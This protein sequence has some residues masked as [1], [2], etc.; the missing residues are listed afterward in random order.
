MCLTYHCSTSLG[1]RNT[2]YVQSLFFPKI[3]SFVRLCGK[4]W[5]SQTGHRWQYNATKRFTFCVTNAT[6][7]RSDYVC[8]I[9]FHGKNG[10]VNT[11]QIYIMRT[12]NVLLSLCSNI[13][14]SSQNFPCLYYEQKVAN[15]S[16][17]L[18]VKT[19]S[20]SWQDFPKNVK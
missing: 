15:F 11:P 10:Y 2:F 7:T 3:V 9:P 14:I 13:G 5:W 12:L 19:V 6:N 4:I 18:M 17:S 16:S 8:W 1:N 20:L